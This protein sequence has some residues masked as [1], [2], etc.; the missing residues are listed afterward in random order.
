M[1][2]KKIKKNWTNYVNQ[3]ISYEVI[4]STELYSYKLMVVEMTGY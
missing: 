4:R 3:K 1:I 2:K